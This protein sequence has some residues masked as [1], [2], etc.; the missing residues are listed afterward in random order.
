MP[1]SKVQIQSREETEDMLGR[2]LSFQSFSYT[3]WIKDW[4]W[5]R[6]GSISGK[7]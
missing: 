2:F 6:T 4:R 1:K 3:Q 5:V 7:R